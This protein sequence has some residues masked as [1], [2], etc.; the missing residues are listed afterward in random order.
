MAVFGMHKAEEEDP[1]RAIRAALAMRSALGDLKHEVGAA[2]DVTLEMRVGID[3][4]EVVV[5]TLGSGRVRSSSSSAR[6]STGPAGS[7]ARRPAGGILISADAYRHVRGSFSVQPMTGLELK[8]IAQPVDGYLVQNER[9]RGF[10]LDDARGVEGVDTRTIGREAQLRQLQDRFDDVAEEQRWH[11]VTVVGDAGV[12][13]SR[14]L[15]DFSRWLDELPEPVWMF[16]RAGGHSGPSQPYALLHDLFATRFDVNDS[17][18]PSEVGR[19]WVRG[20]RGGAGRPT[21]TWS[22]RPTR[23]RSGSGSRSATGRP[24]AADTDPRTLSDRA[25]S[26]LAEYFRRLAERAPVVLALE[27]LH[28]A[29]EAMLSLIDAAHGVLGDCAVLVVAT[30]RP[31]LLEVIP[32]GVKGS[33]STPGSRSTV[34]PGG[35]PASCSPRSSRRQHEFPRRSTTWSS[36]RPRATRSTSRSS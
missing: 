30:T 24:P 19:K 29:D 32:A 25:T 26:Y 2:Y 10:R 21:R 1:H 8:G 18:D 22:S 33:S 14:L 15:S 23:S 28:W 12:G 27:D 20:R 31:T 34:C 35:R 4:G 9:P 16:T 6:S 5:S 7:R 3:T 13:K 36:R 11:V 17:D